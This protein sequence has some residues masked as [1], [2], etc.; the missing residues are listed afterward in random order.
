[1]CM[2][3]IWQLLCQEKRKKKKP[4]TVHI[5]LEEFS[6]FSVERDA[7]CETA[8]F[9]L[10][11][12]T[13]ALRKPKPETKANFEQPKWNAFILRF[14]SDLLSFPSHLTHVGFRPTRVTVQACGGVWCG[15]HYI[16]DKI[17]INKTPAKP[18]NSTVLILPVSFNTEAVN[19]DGLAPLT[20]FPVS[21]STCWECELNCFLAW[22]MTQ[23]KCFWLICVASR[24]EFGSICGVPVQRVKILSFSI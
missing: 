24:L 17:Q 13:L 10:L 22:R 23:S 19:A 6:N 9:C 21:N 1:M 8:N 12:F 7:K 3:R 2:G 15:R 16:W 14:K 5:S 11:L 20:T 18:T 4:F